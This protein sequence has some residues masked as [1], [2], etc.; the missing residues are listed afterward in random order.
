[1][2][3]DWGCGIYAFLGAV[4]GIGIKVEVVLTPLPSNFQT[5]YEKKPTGTISPS[6]IR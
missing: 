1:M 3:F 2:P 4:G 5:A 6:L